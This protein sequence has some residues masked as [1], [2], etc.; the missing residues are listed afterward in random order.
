MDPFTGSQEAMVSAP[1]AEERQGQGYTSPCTSQRE[2]VHPPLLALQWVR[3][4]AGDRPARSRESPGSFLPS[5][6]L[7]NSGQTSWWFL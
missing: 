3:S 7:G 4:T 2:G 5:L 1:P 6:P